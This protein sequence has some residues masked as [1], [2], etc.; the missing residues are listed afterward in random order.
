MDYPMSL[1]GVIVLFAVGAYALHWIIRSA[2]SGA[3]KDFERWKRER[4]TELDEQG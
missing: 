1:I 2:I 4:G 3:M